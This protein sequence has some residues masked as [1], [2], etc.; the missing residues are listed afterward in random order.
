MWGLHVIFLAG[1]NDLIKLTNDDSYVTVIYFFFR[2]D[3]TVPPQF[4]PSGDNQQVTEN[5]IMT[6][7]TM[8]EQRVNDLLRVRKFID[9]QRDSAEAGGGAEGDSENSPSG[10]VASARQQSSRL[11]LPQQLAAVDIKVA[12]PSP[13]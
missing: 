3:S 12:A 11:L 5:N 8:V 1:I 4:S 9:F 10:S 13:G 7:L 6:Y 2:P